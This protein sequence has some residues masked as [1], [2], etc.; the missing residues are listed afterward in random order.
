MNKEQ[1]EV[2][3]W[4]AAVLLA[5]LLGSAPLW[6]GPSDIETAQAVAEDVADAQAQAQAVAMAGARK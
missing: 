2:L 3:T 1:I 5:L 4:V 6:D